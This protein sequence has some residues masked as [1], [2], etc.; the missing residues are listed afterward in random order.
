MSLLLN[1]HY[2]PARGGHAP[3]DLREAFIEAVEAC[4]RWQTRE[5]E[6]TVEVR[7]SAVAIRDV[8]G[9]LWNCSDYLAGSDAMLL[10]MV[11]G[12]RAGTYGA[13]A[14]ALKE[15]VVAQSE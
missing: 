9:Q 10:E 4:R 14:R 15:W 7:D 5:P 8:C 3:N 12:Y 11:C 2:V 6:P 13:A 1:S